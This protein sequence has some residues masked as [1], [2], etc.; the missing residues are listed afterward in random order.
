MVKQRSLLQEVR[1]GL[2]E[3]WEDL[4][5]AFENAKAYFEKSSEPVS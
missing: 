5:A 4:T 1:R 3:A 2:D